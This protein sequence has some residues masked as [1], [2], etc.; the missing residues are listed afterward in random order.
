MID[1]WPTK[2]GSVIICPNGHE[3][4][5]LIDDISKDELFW[6]R[7]FGNWRPGVKVPKWGTSKTK[8]RCPVCD[9]QWIGDWDAM[10]WREPRE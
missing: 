10:R 3:I 5:E 7:K 6:D 1:H 9:A 2:R 4:C 8:C